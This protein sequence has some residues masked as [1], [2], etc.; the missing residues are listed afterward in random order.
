MTNINC[1][2]S[3]SHY[4]LYHHLSQLMRTGALRLDQLPDDALLQV[5]ALLELED[6]LHL[7]RTAARLHSLVATRADPVWKSLYQRSFHSNSTLPAGKSWAKHYRDR[8]CRTQHLQS[9]GF[10]SCD[11]RELSSVA[12]CSHVQEANGH[13]LKRRLK[14]MRAQ[15]S[16]QVPSL[17]PSCLFTCSSE[18]AQAA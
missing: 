16:V 11:C 5:L 10:C 7:S 12:V 14:V 18:L 1:V 8:C 3:K 9:G 15:S 4:H 2:S 17:L 13:R 6:L